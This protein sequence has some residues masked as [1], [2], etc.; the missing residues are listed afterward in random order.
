MKPQSRNLLR[1][2]LLA[3]AACLVIIAIST[4]ISREMTLWGIAA[5]A[6]VLAWIWS[7]FSREPPPE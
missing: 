2:W 6:L 1:W 4:R 7:H 5:S 3:L